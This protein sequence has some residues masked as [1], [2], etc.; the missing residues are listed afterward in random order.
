MAHAE[1][2]DFNFKINR[3]L[4]LPSYRVLKQDLYLM[5]PETGDLDENEIRKN[6]QKPTY[7]NLSLSMDPGIELPMENS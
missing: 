1:K 5:N 4:V 3:P 2:T 7:L 6:E